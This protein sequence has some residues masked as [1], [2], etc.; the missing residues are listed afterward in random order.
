MEFID[1]CIYSIILFKYFYFCYII[2]FVDLLGGIMNNLLISIIY[3]I[4]SFSLTLFIYK[5]YGKYGLYSWIC[6]LVIICNIQTVK[7]ADIFGLTISLGNIS[8]GA[9]FLST[10]ILSEKYGR[11]AANGAT[12]ISFT[13]MVIFAILMYLFLQYE[14]GVSD[15][16]QEAL[17]TVFNYIPRITIGSLLAYYV[18]QRC[19]AYLY[20]LLKKKYNKVWIS[21][22]VS[23]FISQVIDTIIF[24][25][26][27][28]YGNINVQELLN[29]MI[30]MIIFKWII[31]LLDTPFMLLI[32]KISSEGD[33]GI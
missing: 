30:T 7:L 14:P 1:L 4:L 15:S 18:S 23:T 10:D 29:L 5:K 22:N 27:A 19:D 11:D 2:H 24:V 9:L 20:N 13:L 31:A 25:F 26:I 8:Y 6:V 32:M 28:F 33:K 21:N 3:L 16:S 17:I 12:K